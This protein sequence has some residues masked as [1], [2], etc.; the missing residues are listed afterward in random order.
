MKS[1]IFLMF[2]I[3]NYT[4]GQLDSMVVN[5]E[6]VNNDVFSGRIYLKQICD[7]NNQI[8]YG[9]YIECDSTNYTYKLT[10]ENNMRCNKYRL[11]CE[12]LYYEKVIVDISSEKLPLSITLYPIKYTAKE[13]EDVIGES[14]N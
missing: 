14:N 1:L 4:Y 9:K 11:V 13:I 7:S 6:L 2:Y 12:T 5:V 8:L 3:V 10:F